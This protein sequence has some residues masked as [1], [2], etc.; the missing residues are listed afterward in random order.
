MTLERA[1]VDSFGR[2]ELRVNY[3]E[4]VDLFGRDSDD[5]DVQKLLVANGAKTVPPIGKDD[6]DARLFAGTNG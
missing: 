5:A 3:K 2:K 4:W 6:S 1:S